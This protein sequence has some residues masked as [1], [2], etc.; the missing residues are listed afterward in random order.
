MGDFK[1]MELANPKKCPYR[2]M[3]LP[4]CYLIYQKRKS[5]LEEEFGTRWR[6]ANG[7]RVWLGQPC[8]SNHP[9]NPHS[10]PIEI[11]LWY[12]RDGI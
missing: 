11:M 1:H 4:A 8:D 12:H 3:V 2:E 5:S 10:R 9:L 7:F 6:D